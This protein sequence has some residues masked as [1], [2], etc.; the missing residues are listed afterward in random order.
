MSNNNE[1]Q[2][3][4][5]DEQQDKQ[6]ED[7]QRLSKVMA[8][9]GLCSRREAD[10]LISKAQ[11]KVDGTLINTLGIKVNPNCEIEIL[12]QA[13]K[14]LQN[15][16][17]I[18]LHKPMGYVSTPGDDGYPVAISLIEK[19]NQDS[20]VH[21]RSFNKKYLMG[22]APT[23]RLDIDSTGLMIFTQNGVL[24]KKIIGENSNVEK[25]YLV[26]VYG[27]LSDKD[28]KLLNFGL[29]IDGVA[30]KPAKVEWLNED[31]LRFVLK[32]GKKRQI[33]KMCEM[34][35]LE[36]IGLKR[37]R[38]GQIKLEKLKPGEWRF[39]RDDEVV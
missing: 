26:R 12:G 36:V 17:T 16:V 10:E 4:Q 34:V 25:E 6:Q 33:R 32:Q 5:Q 21:V 8:Q 35:G 27:K 29:S 3:K 14:D 9:R 28:L 19:E 23:G 24:A 39:L 7:L 15:K 1:Q 37:V 20:S 30:L 18:L 31:Q 22:L 13:K 11:V 38:I 2:D